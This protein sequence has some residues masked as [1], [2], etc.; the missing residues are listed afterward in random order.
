MAARTNRICTDEDSAGMT[1]STRNVDVGAVNFKA[2]TEVIELFRGKECFR[3]R[4]EDRQQEEQESRPA[5]QRCCDV[6]LQ[7][8]SCNSTFRGP[9][10]ADRFQ[11]IR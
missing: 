9:Q 4:T 3:P 6:R 5:P 7:S 8:Q 10:S 1:I 2:G 11:F